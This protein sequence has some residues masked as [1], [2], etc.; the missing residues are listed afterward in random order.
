MG[1]ET[2]RACYCGGE[3][4]CQHCK[5]DA[6]PPDPLTEAP[7]DA[8]DDAQDAVMTSEQDAGEGTQRKAQFGKLSPSEAAQAR[9]RK[10]RAKQAA[11]ADEAEGKPKQQ[12]VMVRV[13]VEI[14]DIIRRLARDAKGGDVQ[15]ARELRAYLEAYP[16]ETHT[17]ISALDSRTVQALK[18]RLLMEIEEEEGLALDDVRPPA[19]LEGGTPADD[20]TPA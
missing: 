9:W 8:L 14:G 15:S 13:P 20:G 19:E 11:E 6:R 1:S 3:G 12:A 2:E 17:D 4:T 18:A 7:A 16:V 5:E 10:E